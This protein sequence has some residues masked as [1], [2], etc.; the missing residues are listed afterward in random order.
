M[1]GRLE[2]RNQALVGANA[3]SEVDAALRMECLHY[4]VI[5]RLIPQSGSSFSLRVCVC[6]RQGEK[7]CGIWKLQKWNI[8]PS[9]VAGK[10]GRIGEAK[11]KHSSGPTERR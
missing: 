5:Y 10:R 1:V 11:Q 8:Q 9:Q 6:L 4:A 3:S 2:K 7:P